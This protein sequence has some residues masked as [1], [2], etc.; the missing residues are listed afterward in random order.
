MKEID[1][2]EAT[3]LFVTEKTIDSATREENTFA[4]YSSKVNWTVFT[5]ITLFTLGI[6]FY[7]F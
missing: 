4:V 7:Q 1:E 2:Y 3:E 5:L 6:F